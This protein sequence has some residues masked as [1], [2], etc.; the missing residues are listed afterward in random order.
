M[1]ISHYIM[2]TIQHTIKCEQDIMTMMNQMFLFLIL[3]ITQLW[4]SITEAFIFTVC[5]YE[6][7]RKLLKILEKSLAA[8]GVFKPPF[9]SSFASQINNGPKVIKV[10][11]S[12]AQLSM[13]FQLLLKAE[14][15]KN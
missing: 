1:D 14:I 13:K 10:F 15:V 7:D 6:S 12:S 5:L 2:H 11:S 8:K 3:T 4:R 9:G